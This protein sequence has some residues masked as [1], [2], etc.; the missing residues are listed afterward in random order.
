M[1]LDKLEER[2]EI[3]RKAVSDALFSLQSMMGNANTSDSGASAGKFALASVFSYYKIKGELDLAEP[4]NLHEMED[5]LTDKDLIPTQ[6]VLNGKWW[7][8]ARGPIITTD[9]AGEFV[10][11]LPRGMGYRICKPSSKRGIRVNAKTEKELSKDAINIIPALPRQAMSK[12]DFFRYCFKIIPSIDWFIILSFCVLSTLLAMLV[13]IANKVLFAEV[14]PSGATSAIFPI[15]GFLLASSISS[16]VFQLCRNLVLV[17]TKDR[18]NSV[19]QLALIERLLNLPAAFFKKFSSGNLSQKVLGVS[20]IY[21]LLTSQILAVIA[22][23]VFSIMYVLIA[24]VYAKSMIWLVTLTVIATFGVSLLQ[25][26]SLTRKYRTAF[27]YAMATRDFTHN[28]LLGIQKIKNSRS[29]QRAFKQ[30][31]DRFS[32]SE[33]IL[34]YPKI[35]GIVLI[36]FCTFF[37]WYT[38][39]KSNM[40][41]SDYVAFMSAFGVMIASLGEFIPN[42]SS[43]AQLVPYIEKLQPV[44]ETPVQEDENLPSVDN[45]TGSIDINNVSFRY[46]EDSPLILD[47]VSLHINAGENIGIVGS[48]GCGKSTLMRL[49]LG[50]EEPKSG[51]I[52]YGPYNISKVKVGSLR[53]YVGFCPQSMQIF[54]SSIA[55]NIRFSSIQCTMDDIWEA[56]RIACIDED[57]KRMPEGMNTILGEGGTGLSGGQCQRLLIARSVINKPKVL[58]LDEATSALDNITQR[59]VVENLSIMGCTRIAIAHRLSTVMSCDRIIVLDKGKV[60]E[61]GSP[62]ELIEKRGFFYQLSKRQQ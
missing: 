38:A 40:A 17:R 4:S 52:F 54:P 21:Q 3:N 2:Y 34:K 60:V 15:C 11:V 30:W 20:E 49:L 13:P 47:N 46:G 5:A 16:I 12:S 26:R 7:E 58:F 25:F 45:I 14:I 53:Q 57:I 9:K 51:S 36:S 29:E 35:P 39:W 32:K 50:F 41:V 10:A 59:K 6:I 24:F 23:G 44:L 1:F 27:H 61:D 42:L 22:S 43:I 33:V 31:S 37:A 48:S 56:A 28:A 55:E 8:S 62:K 18:F 19:V